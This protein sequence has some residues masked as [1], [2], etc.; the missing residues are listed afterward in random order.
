MKW[1]LI[2]FF[3]LLL[4]LPLMAT[5]KP[6]E[7]TVLK[8]GVSDL[9]KVAGFEKWGTTD[10][11][12]VKRF[13]ELEPGIKV[14]LTDAD[15]SQGNTITID[16]LVAAGKAPDVY[17]DHI[18]RVGKFIVPEYALPI[19]DYVDLS[20]LNPKMIEQ[21]KRGGKVYG[22]PLSL[23]NQGMILNMDLLEAIGYKV[24]DNWTL[25]D[26]RAMAKLVKE[27]APGKY[28]TV[29]FAQN[30]SGDYFFMNWFA[31]FGVK[32]Y[33]EGYKESTFEK[34]GG[35]KGLAWFMEMYNNGWI[36]KEAANLNDD[37]YLLMLSKGEVATGGLYLGHLPIL[38]SA[39]KQGLI[40]KPITLK[41]VSF[42]N[43]APAC[44]Q[45]A[46]IV[47]HNTKDKKRNEAIAK[48]IKFVTSAEYQ[49][50]DTL[51]Q[52][53]VPT[54]LAVTAKSAHPLWPGQVAV[55]QKNGLYDLGLA[56][57]Q[58][59]EIRKQ[60]YPLLQ[61]M[62]AGELTP[63]QVAKMYTENVNKILAKK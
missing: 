28:A 18:S 32:F 3:S 61:R 51:Y 53:S 41:Y 13:A 15:I 33:S 2:L 30:Q 48:Y 35:A 38:E 43:N 57:P 19:S 46:G 17:Q 45:L 63:D 55:A 44:I 25:D 56:L 23:V 42:P 39:V 20:Y 54:A 9:S 36:P 10:N 40:D 12:F 62:Y 6:I 29:L 7:I 22:L 4:V 47:G 58:F 34:T 37:D 50:L 26:F 21:F 59:G 14:I 8:A 16:S 24:P 5:E 31:S 11:Y 60:M 49:T 52:G 1:I 27:K